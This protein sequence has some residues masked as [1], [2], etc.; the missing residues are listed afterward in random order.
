[1]SVGVQVRGYR[2]L[3]SEYGIEILVRAGGW[4]LLRRSAGRIRGY[5][6]ASGWGTPDPRTAIQAVRGSE[7]ML[8]QRGGSL[9]R[10][11]RADLGHCHVAAASDACG[12]FATDPV[13]DGSL[14]NAAFDAQ[15]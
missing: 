13:C 7:S 4:R 12:E 11:G 5:N 9:D 10:T 1:M 3:S 2:R 14:S 6:V 8:C 15:F